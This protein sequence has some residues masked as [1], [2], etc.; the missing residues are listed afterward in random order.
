M[1][2]IEFFGGQNHGEKRE[3]VCSD[4]YLVPPPGS[5]R[6]ELINDI[7]LA[8]NGQ[9]KNFHA[10]FRFEYQKEENG[11]WHMDMIAGASLNAALTRCKNTGQNFYAYRFRRIS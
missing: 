10:Q 4:K 8:M 6:Y 1:K 5:E 11:Q 7:G 3:I 9:R 2:T